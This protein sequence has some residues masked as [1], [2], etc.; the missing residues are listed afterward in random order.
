MLYLPKHKVIFLCSTEIKFL[1]YWCKAP[2][3]DSRRLFQTVE[4]LLQPANL[5]RALPEQQSLVVA[6][7]KPPHQE[8]HRE[9]H[10]WCLTN[11]VASGKSLPMISWS[12]Q[13]SSS[14]SGRRYPHNPIHTP[15]SNI[16]QLILLLNCAVEFRPPS[17]LTRI[18]ESH[19]WINHASYWNVSDWQSSFELV[20]SVA[21]NK[22]LGQSIGLFQG[23]S[24]TSWLVGWSGYSHSCFLFFSLG[25]HWTIWKVCIQP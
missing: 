7:C 13:M 22:I 19:Y 2:K 16:W 14:R 24:G 10:S 8:Y 4:W 1:N 20:C 6:P 17:F 15:V 9:R 18:S 3:S 11:E 23:I 5:F 25:W 12:A 21:I